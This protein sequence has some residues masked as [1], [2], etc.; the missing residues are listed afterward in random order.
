MASNL[1]CERATV[2]IKKPMLSLASP[3][4]LTLSGNSGTEQGTKLTS[5]SGNFGNGPFHRS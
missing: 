2:A 5:N 3:V 4:R 1:Q